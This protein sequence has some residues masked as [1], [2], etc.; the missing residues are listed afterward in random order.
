MVRLKK[1]RKEKWASSKK[2]YKL[3]LWHWIHFLGKGRVKGLIIKCDESTWLRRER[4]KL[5]GPK[6]KPL[7]ECPER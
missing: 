1:N 7:K 5:N 2:M 3:N 4:R 6:K